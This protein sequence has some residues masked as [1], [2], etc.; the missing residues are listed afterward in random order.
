MLALTLT[1]SVYRLFETPEM[2][3]AFHTFVCETYRQYHVWNQSIPFFVDGYWYRCFSE[4]MLEDVYDNKTIPAHLPWAFRAL[5][6]YDTKD[7][8]EIYEDKWFDALLEIS[9]NV[10]EH[11]WDTLQEDLFLAF[12]ILKLDILIPDEDDFL[13]TISE[14]ANRGEFYLETYW[15]DMTA[16][17]SYPTRGGGFSCTN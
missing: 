2:V 15:L 3:D 13:T 4:A 14:V 11:L 9:Q 1:R 6:D 7:L 8:L 12:Q 10:A 16:T 5:T 17:R